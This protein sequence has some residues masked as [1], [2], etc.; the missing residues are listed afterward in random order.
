MKSL[1]SLRCAVFLL[2]ALLLAA[3]SSINSAF[4]NSETRLTEEHLLSAGFKI[5]IADTKARQEM[6]HSLAPETISRIPRPDNVYYIYADP[7]LCSCL[8][9]GRE[10]EYRKLQ[11]LAADL[12]ISDEQMIANE[13]R[14]DQQ[15]GWGPTGAWGKWGSWGMNPNSM[16]RPAWDP[17]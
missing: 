7:V 14:E 1:P 6:L 15:A 17:N 9:V 2:T 12:R 3:C 13:I 5:M 11:Q 16:G 10:I 4:R 8:Y